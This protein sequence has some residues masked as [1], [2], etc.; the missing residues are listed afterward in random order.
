MDLFKRI[1]TAAFTLTI[2]SVGGAHADLRPADASIAIA[3]G[4]AH[5]GNDFTS[6]RFNG[7]PNGTL[8]V[9]LFYHDGTVDGNALLKLQLKAPSGAMGFIHI[10]TGYP[11]GGLPLQADIETRQYRIGDCRLTGRVEVSGVVGSSTSVANFG[12]AVGLMVRY[13]DGTY[14]VVK[15][16]DQ[17]ANSQ[18]FSGMGYFPLTTQQFAQRASELTHSF[19]REQGW[20]MFFGSQTIGNGSAEMPVR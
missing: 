13:S 12:I 5:T 16:V 15:S 10:G 14:R 8:Q 7:M 18:D 2:L 9:T 3:C 6:N 1:L 19:A 17:P 20:M 4:I 11:G